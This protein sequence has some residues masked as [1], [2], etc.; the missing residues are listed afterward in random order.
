MSLLYCIVPTIYSQWSFIIIYIKTNTNHDCIYLLYG[1]QNRFHIEI[2]TS[3][4]KNKQTKNK[5][6]DVNVVNRQITKE[7]LNK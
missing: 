4:R 1:H 3:R 2:Q 7:K 6:T 5:T